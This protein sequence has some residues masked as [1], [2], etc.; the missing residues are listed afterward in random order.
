MVGDGREDHRDEVRWKDA[1]TCVS[2]SR[3][4]VS[5]DGTDGKSR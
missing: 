2:M 1:R 5:C 3:S 4:G